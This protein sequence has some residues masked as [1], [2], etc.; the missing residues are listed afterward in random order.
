MRAWAIR[1]AEADPQGETIGY[2]GSYVRGDW[3]WERR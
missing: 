3:G 2:F 1:L